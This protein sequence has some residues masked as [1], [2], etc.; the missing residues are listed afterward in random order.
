MVK[1]NPFYL[2]FIIKSVL[3]GITS[4]IVLPFS[5][6]WSHSLFQVIRY[7]HFFLVLPRLIYLR[8]YRCIT[9]RYVNNS[10]YNVHIIFS[11]FSLVTST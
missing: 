8:Q 1:S 4:L 11:D 3:L 2:T 9:L 5:R 10:S 7:K 6:L